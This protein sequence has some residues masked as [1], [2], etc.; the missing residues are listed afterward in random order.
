MSTQST[1]TPPELA[2]IAVV[3]RRERVDAMFK[4]L[5][6]ACVYG[7]PTL[8]FEGIPPHYTHGVTGFTHNG[9]VVIDSSKMYKKY[10]PI[11]CINGNLF[12]HSSQKGTMVVLDNLV[13][14]TGTIFIAKDCSFVAPQ[15]ETVGG[16]VLKGDIELRKS[17]FVIGDIICSGSRSPLSN[18][19]HAHDLFLETSVD[20]NTGYI[21]LPK[22]VTGSCCL[23]FDVM[24]NNS[25][26]DDLSPVGLRINGAEFVNELIV[27]ADYS[28]VEI[29]FTSTRTVNTLINYT[30]DCAPIPT[31]R[32]DNLTYMGRLC[33]E[34]ICRLLLGE[35]A[36]LAVLPSQTQH[37]NNAS[38]AIVTV[39]KQWIKYGD[40]YFY[41]NNIIFKEHVRLE[42]ARALGV[43]AHD[44]SWLIRVFNNLPATGEGI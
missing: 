33:V 19:T 38:S 43:E 39:S 21:S 17:L 28:P 3:D 12:I 14:V 15:L 30:P 24:S 35:L 7:A 8:C 22:S 40:Y 23:L 6:A 26:K 29:A 31:L 10:A 2:H 42:I 27:A 11:E 9:D 25:A 13:K 1:K 16:L 41:P 37:L 4:T 5:N 18:V 36:H 34:K 32:F 20:G 44:M